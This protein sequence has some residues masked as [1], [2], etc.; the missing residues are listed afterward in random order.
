M[1]S[2]PGVKQSNYHKTKKPYSP[3]LGGLKL[4]VKKISRQKLRSSSM[5]FTKTLKEHS[6]CGTSEIS[7]LC[8]QT[9]KQ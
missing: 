2:K 7:V 6:A 8:P 9:G 1:R 4:Q 5:N 3:Q